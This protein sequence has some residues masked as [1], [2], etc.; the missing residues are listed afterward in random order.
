MSYVVEEQNRT[1]FVKEC[2]EKLK[3]IFLVVERPSFEGVF[4]HVLKQGLVFFLESLN[5]G[6]ME[7]YL[8]EDF[9]EKKKSPNDHTAGGG[10]D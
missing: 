5:F 8:Y 4:I 1:L 10:G 7:M 3:C 2:A 6:V 9:I